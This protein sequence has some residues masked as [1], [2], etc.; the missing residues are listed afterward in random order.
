MVALS[1]GFKA[2]TLGGFFKP[3][4]IVHF[5][6]Y[7]MYKKGCVS[8]NRDISNFEILF[9]QKG[10]FSVIC[11]GKSV[12]LKNGD[13]FI[14]RPF[15][16]YQVIGLDES[17]ISIAV[18]IS[19][20]QNFFTNIESDK[21]FLRPFTDRKKGEF[22]VYRSDEFIDFSVY[23]SI[24]SPLRLY[25]DKNLG[26]CHFGLAIG[27]LI[28]KLCLTFDEK[29]SISSSINSEEYEVRIFDYIISNCYSGNL[30]VEKIMKKFSVSKWYIDKVTKK[31][32]GYGYRHTIKSL[33]MWQAHK[34]MATHTELREVGRLCGFID[35]SGF[36][37][38]YKGFF[39]V[40]PTED[41]AFFNEKGK[42]MADF[43]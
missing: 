26:L 23:P 14:A 34:L 1:K 18:H 33:R 31:F 27:M 38:C 39:G 7:E 37:R 5:V 21:K 17:K 41:M 28:T 13:I 36:Y 22:N 24:I 16:E 35:Y 2:V 25:I 32:Y 3:E 9:I 4:L 10:E 20:H 29:S 43:W 8:N 30:T 40:S 12:T 19:F 15:E 11:E 6:K 42:F